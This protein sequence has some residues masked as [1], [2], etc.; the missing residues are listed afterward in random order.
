MHAALEALL[1]EI[2]LGPELDLAQPAALFARLEALGVSDSDARA[3]VETELPR[4][5]TYRR[6]VRGTLRAALE[7]AIPRSLARLGANF[8]PVFDRFL[9]EH[10]PRSH[11][12][13]DVTRELLDFISQNGAELPSYWLDLARHEALHIEV[14]ALPSMRAPA[15]ACA[16]SL[17]SGLAFSESVRLV[18][19]DYAV[20]E[21]PEDLADQ[22]EPR[23]ERTHILAYRDAEHDV[24]YLALSALAADVLERLLAGKSLGQSLAEAAP[25]LD[26]VTLDATASLL[27]DLAERGVIVGPRAIGSVLVESPATLDPTADSPRPL[28]SETDP[29]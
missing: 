21:L 4:L 6:L 23:H 16:L 1:A 12:L 9:A 27:A 28:T 25:E 22:S 10:G 13:R 19:Y 17:D 29:P 15:E 5:L 14:A 20:H 24:R 26:A 8:E 7:R 2:V 18:H 11:Y 3:L